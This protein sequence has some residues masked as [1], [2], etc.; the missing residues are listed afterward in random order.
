MTR[1]PTTGRTSP[2]QAPPSPLTDDSV[3]AALPVG[4]QLRLL[5][6]G[7]HERLRQLQRLHDL[8]Q[9]QLQRLLLRPGSIPIRR[10]PNSLIA[11]WWEDLNPSAGG[12]VH[13]QTL[14]S[15]PNRVFILQF[16]NIQHYSAAA[17]P[18]TMQ[19]KLFETT[20]VIEVHYQAAPSD[21]GTHSA[22]IENADGTAG[23][24]CY[25]GTATLTTPEAVRYAPMPVYY[26][27]RHRHRHGDG[28]H[29]Q[30]R[31]Q[32]AQPEQHAAAQHVDHPADDGGQ[33]RPRQ[34]ELADR[35][36]ARCPTARTAQRRRRP[37]GG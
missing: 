16:T 6:D 14:G 21:G 7:L 23:V 33:H 30:H 29:P 35:R 28:A 37:R 31:R 9:R 36:G 18:V 2:A 8:C 4:L 17:T 34:P 20:N 12:T 10:R 13:Y 32:P 15:A 27:D 11:G 1:S 5:R 24:Q 3:S 22:G 19:F 26:G 25:Y